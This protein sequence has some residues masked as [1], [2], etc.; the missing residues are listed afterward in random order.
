MKRVLIVG[1]GSGG[2]I[3][4]NTLSAQLKKEIKR[5]EVEITVLDDRGKHIYQPGYLHVAFKG[6]D[7]E[8]IVKDEHELLNPAVNFQIDAARDIDLNEREIKTEKGKTLS[9][10]YLILSTGCRTNPDLIPGLSGENYDFH[11]SPE[12]SYR[13][14]KAINEFKSGNIV[15]GITTLP[16]MCPPSPNESVF[17]ADEFFRKKGIRDRVDI[18]FITPYPRVYPAE[19]ISECIE[20]LFEERDIRVETFFNIDSID[21]E[22]GKIFS[23]EGDEIDY[24]LISLIP[25]HEG[26][27]VIFDSE[28][29]D[30][31]G[32]I[33]AD[34]F[35]MLVQNFDDAFAIGDCTAIPISK[36]GVVAHLQAHTVSATIADGI[37]GIGGVYRYNGRINCPLEIGDGKCTF[38]VSDYE[39]PIKKIEPSRIGYL[40]KWMIGKGYWK[41]LKGGLDIPMK[42]YFGETYHK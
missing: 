22:A 3:A 8:K 29:G 34:R 26:S 28:I 38:V 14:W 39:E 37:R 18:T 25:P 41:M 10:D 13:T 20:P 27:P 19:A 17:L 31:E 30:E 11:T 7:P 35:T 1:A 32:W 12:A 33:E 15:M 40:Q 42:F 16:H 36:S 9:Y 2:T 23:M 24:D 4:A 21:P 6:A 5:N